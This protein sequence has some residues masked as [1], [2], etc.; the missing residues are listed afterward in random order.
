M[1]LRP[2]RSGRPARRQ[3]A[4]AFGGSRAPSLGFAGHSVPA[5][6]VSNTATQTRMSN[7]GM[8]HWVPALAEQRVETKQ[9]QVVATPGITSLGFLS[10]IPD[11]LA[12]RADNWA[13]DLGTNDPTFAMFEENMPKIMDAI[14]R[15]GSRL[16]LVPVMPRNLVTQA[17]RDIYQAMAGRAIEW[18][19]M[20]IH[21]NLHVIDTAREYGDPTSATWSP[22]N[23]PGGTYDLLHTAGLGAYRTS[24]AIAAFFKSLYPPS[25]LITM[26]ANQF[27]AENWRGNLIPNGVLL[28]NGGTGSTNQGC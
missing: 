13:L 19:R 28:G 14:L 15:S 21:P 10:R 5:S 26:V 20:G 12:A 27:S 3:E 2:L 1:Q 4:L 22:K 9:S 6:G 25:S 7:Y 8:P 23:D 11:V 18:G 17:T 24:K 16:I